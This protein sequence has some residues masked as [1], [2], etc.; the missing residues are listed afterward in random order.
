MI[1]A[2]SKRLAGHFSL[3]AWSPKAWTRGALVSALGLAI[4]VVAAGDPAEARRLNKDQITQLD[5]V[6]DYFNTIDTLSGEF[7]Q[8]DSWGSAAHGQF[9]FRR[10]GRMRFQ[11]ENPPNLTIIAD[12]TWY[13]VNDTELRTVDRFPL[14]STPLHIFLRDEV[15]LAED[16]R[17]V[18][19]Q[20]AP[21]ELIVVAKDESGLVQGALEMVFATPA[22][23]LRRWSVT[24]AQGITTTVA[25]RN[26]VPG[27]KLD[28]ALFVPEERVAD[29]D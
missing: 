23:E 20:E 27:G 15:D 9:F 2:F 6:S 14:R 19:V 10:P 22:L 18:D 16:K 28:P 21:G 3:K 24:D 25:L 1:S 11:Y 5:D 8:Q 12:G 7:I 17:V 29:E 4:L 26:V 13:M